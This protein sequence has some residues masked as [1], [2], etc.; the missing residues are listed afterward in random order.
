MTCYNLEFISLISQLLRK[1]Q[2]FQVDKFLFMN[3][4]LVFRSYV[5]NEV[6]LIRQIISKY[7]YDF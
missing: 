1:W 3:E 2:G 5:S 7:L 4:M 6:F